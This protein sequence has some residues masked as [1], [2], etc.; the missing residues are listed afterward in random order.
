MF[1]S[2]IVTS[3]RDRETEIRMAPL[4]FGEF[5]RFKK[6]EKPE[7]WNEYL[8]YGG[9]PIATLKSARADREAYLSILFEKAYKA[10]V[11]ERQGIENEYALDMLINALASSVDSLTN[12]TKLSNALNSEAHAST[13]DTTMKKHLDALEDAFLFSKAQRWGVKGKR[14]FNYPLK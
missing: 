4:T 7:D 12:P 1:S 8:A 14:Y 3:F 6:G 10:D 2:D 11:V 9:V 13:T 5:R